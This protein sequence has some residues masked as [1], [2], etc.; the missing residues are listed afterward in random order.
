M[1]LRQRDFTGTTSNEVT[2]R[3]K[4]A[5]KLVR[6]AASEGFVLLKNDSQ[7][8]PLPPKSKLALYGA[9]AGKTI[10]GGTGS[11][12]VNERESVSIY[13][14]L[15]HA[16]YEITTKEW[17][18]S[19]E[20]CYRKAREE[21]SQTIQNKMKEENLPFYLAYFNTPFAIP[22]GNLPEKRAEDDDADVAVYVLSR[23]SGEGADRIA[24]QGDYFLTE[25]ELSLL[26]R[27][28]GLYSQILLV[29]NIGG[30]VD[31]GF[32]EEIP[33]IKSILLFGQAGQ[34]GGNA[35]A[36]VIS[37]KVIPSGKLTDTWTRN[38][39]DYPV[40]QFPNQN[41]RRVEYRE[42]IYVG[43]R[44]FDTFQVPVRYSF[45]F[46]LSYTK[47]Q[48]TVENIS[49]DER[50]ERTPCLKIKAAVK[51]IGN[52][53][54]GKEVVQVYISCPQN[55][56]EKEFRRL[57]AFE[58]TRELE[59]EE[60]QT[61]ELWIPLP[62]LASYDE[63]NSAWILEEGSYGIWIGNA[64][65]NAGLVGTAFLEKET[66]V[67]PCRKICASRSHI[68]EIHPDR[69]GQK[70]REEEWQREAQEKNLPCVNLG[71]PLFSELELSFSGTFQHISKQA[72]QMV[73]TLSEEELI[74][75]TI[76]ALDSQNQG[77]IGAAGKSVPGAAAETTSIL[78]DAPHYLGGI[79]LAD[80]PAGLRI[81]QTYQ[82]KDGQVQDNGAIGELE[83]QFFPH[84]ENP[85]GVTYYQYC[86]A[87]P[88][89]TLVAQTWNP[90][91]AERLGKMIGQEMQLFEISLWLAPGMNIHRNP[92]GGRN[93]EYYS[94]DPW[95]TGKT[96]AAMVRGV[97]SVSGC[98]A[99][100]KHFACNNQEQ[101]RLQS[102][103]IVSE[104]ALRE[105]YLRGFEGAIRET[106]PMAVMTAYNKINGIYAANHED[107]CTEV[108]RKEWKFAGVIMT[109]WATTVSS[110]DGSCSA[111]GC[112]KAGNDLIMPGSDIDFCNIQN[113]VDNGTLPIE[114]VKACAYRMIRMI[115][116][117][118]QY[119]DAPVYNH[120]FAD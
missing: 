85:E 112:M 105:I 31:L 6:K 104:R 15:L 63:E 76:G 119:E 20:D 116:Q 41:E 3:E 39:N 26:K 30:I 89:G 1:R 57:A 117:T 78:C 47:F 22:A 7:L 91:L 80:G 27:I 24:G 28:A 55:R 38:L 62:S 52:S 111:A 32:T 113:A 40:M 120:Q 42:G 59:P 118:N 46:G 72:E 83:Q 5:G 65:E 69:R 84:R 21:W 106:Q 4:E 74:A 16:G 114:K 102:D 34:E 86:T 67:C 79:V 35:F 95:L 115:L 108:L 50:Q 64:L 77:I 110:E 49:L 19:Y 36:D 75:V 18:M 14:G 25:A 60:T 73:N 12:D 68:E 54:K 61:I 81:R 97:Q 87:M 53:Y 9:G 56:L 101:E 93:F 71:K 10:K 103:S 13:Q 37:G 99:T 17:L 44:Y 109:D 96:A 58:K 100:I 66:I 2:E 11:G 8:L 92:L 33:E 70:K 90:G 48:I 51:N 107:L 98:G 88:V 82:V 45:G 43:Y 23:S 94:E 29:L